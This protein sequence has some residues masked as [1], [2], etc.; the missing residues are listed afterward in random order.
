MEAILTKPDDAAF[1]RKVLAL[2]ETHHP[3]VASLAK[4]TE[5]W[6]KAAATNER[7]TKTRWMLFSGRSGTGKTHATKAAHKFLR[8]AAMALWPRWYPGPP[9][10]RYVI[11]SKAVALERYGWEDLEDEIRACAMVF[12]DDVGS[13][14][15]RFR[16]GEPAERLRL[17]LDKCQGKWLLMST[18][19]ARHDF[20]KTFDSRVQSRLEMAA[21]LDLSDVPDF[22]PRLVEGAGKN[23]TAHQQGSV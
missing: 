22:R 12:V 6:I 1:R 16:T 11:W 10:M 21:C 8:G 18:N 7:G 15:D 17:F 9:A 13:E 20:A 2:D 23:E 14:I 3:K 5:R 4:W 19:V